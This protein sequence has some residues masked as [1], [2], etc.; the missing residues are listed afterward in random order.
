[1]K[2]SSI[3]KELSVP[4]LGA[5]L[6]LGLLQPFNIDKVQEGRIL[7]ILSEVALSLLSI[8]LSYIILKYIFKMEFK[9]KSPSSYRHK[10]CILL[11]LINLPI[12]SVILW[13]FNNWFFEADLDFGELKFYLL[14]VFCISAILYIGSFLRIRSQVLK[15]ELDDVKAIN[16]LLEERQQK[17]EKTTDDETTPQ[18]SEEK[19]T[20][21]GQ[22]NKASLEVLP[23]DIVYV[24]SM[25]NYA[26]ICYL[27]NGELRH[28]TLRLTLK[29]IKETLDSYDFLIQCHRAFLV[30]LNFAVSL[31]KESTGY[32]IHIFGTEKNIPVSRSNTPL[33][34]EKLQK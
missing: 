34:K 33:I 29:V 9:E 4:S 26:D 14:N 8:V 18:K 17:W 10:E 23:E 12:L 3:L 32:T 28:K 1:M 25:A 15:E 13:I 11:Y 24:E 6:I 22:Y 5:L 27:E 19:C 31:S 2:A 20:F 30:N 7:F 21:T 16:A